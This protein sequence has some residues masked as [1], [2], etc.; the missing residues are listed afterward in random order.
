MVKI[1]RLAGL[2][3]ERGFVQKT[4]PLTK[5]IGPPPCEIG[6]SLSKNEYAH[7][8]EYAHILQDPFVFSCLYLVLPVCFFGA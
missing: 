5:K 1:A 8:H 4:N 7:I 2:G 3:S 6:D